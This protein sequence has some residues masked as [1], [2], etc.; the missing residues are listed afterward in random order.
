MVNNVLLSIFEPL[1][2][3]Q[4]VLPLFWYYERVEKRKKNTSDEQSDKKTPCVRFVGSL[5]AAEI[6]KF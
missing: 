3:N 4:C 6:Y 5:I 1:Q 2:V